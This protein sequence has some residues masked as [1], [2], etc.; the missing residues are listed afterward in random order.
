MGGGSLQGLLGHACEEYDRL[1]NM[2]LKAFTAAR[3]SP[4]EVL[5]HSKWWLVDDR[6]SCMIKILAR[7]A[8]VLFWS[9][10]N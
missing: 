2:Q 9:L 1:E 5:V 8:W 6:A 10:L 4:A 3:L 7:G